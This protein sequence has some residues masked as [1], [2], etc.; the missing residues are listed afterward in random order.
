MVFT[1]AKHSN[2]YGDWEILDVKAAGLEAKSIVSQKI[3]SLD[4]RLVIKKRCLK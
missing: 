3:F 4:M 1:S 2:W